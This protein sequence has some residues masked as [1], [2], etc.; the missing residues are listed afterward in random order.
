[1][2]K[3]KHIKEFYYIDIFIEISIIFF[4]DIFTKLKKNNHFYSQTLRLYRL[5]LQW[6]RACK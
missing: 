2:L 3:Y 4:I 5:S 1:M 6:R